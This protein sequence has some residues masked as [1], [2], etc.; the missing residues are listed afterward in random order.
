MKTEE[1]LVAEGDDAEALL[2]SQAF[3]GVVNSLIETTFEKFCMSGDSQEKEREATYQ[4]Y[5]ALANL[6]D[7]LK[8]RVAVRDQ[9]NER[10]SESRSEEE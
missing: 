10:A 1:N 8:E 4:G 5:R 9:I 6:V 7:T 3:S 2:N